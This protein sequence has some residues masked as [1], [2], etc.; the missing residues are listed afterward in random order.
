MA[1]RKASLIVN[2]VAIEAVTRAHAPRK[3]LRKVQTTMMSTPMRTRP[4]DM[5]WRN[6]MMVA[7]RGWCWMMVPLQ[8]GQ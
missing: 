4:L 1:P 5:R 8:S 2:T 6:S 7:A 3:V